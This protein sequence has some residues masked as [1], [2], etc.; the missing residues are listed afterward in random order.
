[1]GVHV[2]EAG[3][4]D[5]AGRVERTAG[6]P[7]HATNA[8]DSALAHRHVGREGRQ[9]GPVDDATAADDEV[10]RHADGGSP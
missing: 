9:A 1:V 7:V 2:D 10:P 3:G 4:D 5:R 6:G 8:G